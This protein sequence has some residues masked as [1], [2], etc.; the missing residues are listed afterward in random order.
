M[1]IELSPAA[2]RDL[3][4]LERPVR[5]EL[6]EAIEGLGNDPKPDGY[7]RRKVAGVSPDLYRLKMGSWRILYELEEGLVYVVG[8]VARKD[9]E[10]RLRKLR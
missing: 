8:V 2:Q 10:R 7:L 9:L 6:L 1:R 4:K 3:K 5:E